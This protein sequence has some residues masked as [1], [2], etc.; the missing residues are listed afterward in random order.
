MAQFLRTPFFAAAAIIATTAIFLRGCKTKSKS[1]K[2]LNQNGENLLSV[3]TFNT[4]K[5]A[6]ADPPIDA[7]GVNSSKYRAHIKWQDWDLRKSAWV[8]FFREEDKKGVDVLR[9]FFKFLMI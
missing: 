4:W 1:Q 2:Y 3:V 9:I 6:P 8:D 7:F 5:N